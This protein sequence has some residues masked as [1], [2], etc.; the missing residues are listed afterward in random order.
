MATFSSALRKGMQQGAL[1]RSARSQDADQ[2][3]RAR[4]HGDAVER[5]HGAGDADQA[6]QGV[7]GQDR[8]E[9]RPLIGRQ[10]QD[11]AREEREDL[12]RQ[13]RT[14]RE[15]AGA[16]EERLLQSHGD[17]DAVADRRRAGAAVDLRLSEP[18]R[19]AL[20]LG[21]RLALRRILANLVGNAIEYGRT[22]HLGLDVGDGGVSP[23][24]VI[25]SRRTM[26]S[27]P[28]RTVRAEGLDARSACRCSRRTEDRF[29]AGHSTSRYSRSIAV[30]N[31]CVAVTSS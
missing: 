3:A 14:D 18:A 28:S 19:G 20:V 23:W 24:C 16:D 21:D 6:G 8:G 5:P 9:Q 1:A 17:D 7:D 30:S 10:D 15:S 12:L 13:E 29:G 27:S 11:A 31:A 22:A 4:L 26:A 2:L 25:W